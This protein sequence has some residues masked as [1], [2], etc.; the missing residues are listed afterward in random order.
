[1][2]FS[3]KLKKITNQTFWTSKA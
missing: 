3:I 1:M 2:G